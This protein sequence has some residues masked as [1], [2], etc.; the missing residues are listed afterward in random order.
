[1]N[2]VLVAIRTASER[3]YGD[4]L[5]T[6]TQNESAKVR[7]MM[8]PYLYRYWKAHR[9][10]GW[11]L[12]DELA[13]YFSNRLG[14]PRE[15]MVEVIGG[16]ALAIV[17]EFFDDE[18]IMARL[19]QYLAELVKQAL[20]SPIRRALGRSVL[21]KV[22]LA[23]LTKA[24]KEQ[25]EYQP[26][27]LPEMNQS[28]PRP[29]VLDALALQA[30]EVLE[31]P[32]RDVDEIVELLIGPDPG[33]DLLLM[34]IAER[35]LVVEGA[36][37]PSS[38]MGALDRIFH[39]G[40]PWLRQSVLYA[41]GK[42]L[43]TSD[44]K[45]SDPAWLTTFAE[46]TLEFIRATGST[47]ETKIG[48][49]SLPSAMVAVESVFERH[50]P[51]G[52]ARFIP[53]YFALAMSAGDMAL[54]LRVIKATHL[55]SLQ[56]Q[57]LIALDALSG[58]VDATIQHPELT[59]P[60]VEVLAN[61]RMFEDLSVDRF[62]AR[63]HRSDLTTSVL[64][65]PPSL[66]V[67]EFPTMLDFFINHQLINSEDGRREICGMFRRATQA[68]SSAGLLHELVIWAIGLLTGENIGGRGK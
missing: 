3:G 9:E 50:S 40:Y 41:T 60:V 21:L 2:A 46:L 36:R 29:P 1:V 53:E 15:E 31:H 8:V 59:M 63:K 19:G 49:Y 22:C 39:E 14:A 23:V 28:F 33:Y 37:D 56:G 42:I 4:Q 47:L 24:A 44:L 38:T 67:N 5:V 61:I 27:N 35:A 11:R 66:S 7:V 16:L 45:T 65:T 57:P 43:E 52:T 30:L 34:L 25:P 12:L 26:L 20:A 18:V 62:L 55:L 17:A 48:T 10:E 51:T 13:P 68:N 32:E 58:I 64:A 6:L 54:A